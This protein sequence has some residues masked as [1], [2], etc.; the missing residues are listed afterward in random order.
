MVI[1]LCSAIWYKDLPT[2]TYLCRNV[3]RGMVVCGL[4]HG[5]CIDIMS[6][7]GK[8]RSVLS[9]PDSVG[10]YE[11]GF[12]TSDNRFVDRVEGMEIAINANQCIREPRGQ[13]YSEDLY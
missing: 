6:K 12:L 7:L 9:G 10:D 2:Q 11:Q 13:L 8:M 5:H 4:R 1:I 3:D